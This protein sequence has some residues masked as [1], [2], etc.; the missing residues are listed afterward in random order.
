MGRW[1]RV[2][3]KAVVILLG[4]GIVALGSLWWISKPTL[5][6]AF[7][8]PTEALPPNPGALIRVEPF[9]RMVPSN[10]QAWRILYTTTRYDGTIAPA[11]AII[12]AS[13]KKTDSPSDV[14]AWTH[15]T[16]GFASACAPSVMEKPF[17][18][19][20][21]LAE[22]IDNG[23]VVVATDYIGL[24]T[25]GPH[26]YLIGEGEARSALDS[27]RAA[28]QM[29]EI[30][31]SDRTIVWGHS[32]GG[33]A[34]MWTGILASSYAPEINL[35]GIAAA[36]PASDLPGLVK[37]AEKTPVGKI[38]SAYIISAYSQT[39]ADVSFDDNV[40]LLARPIVRDMATRCMEGTK[41][42]FLVGQA[43]IAG[44]TIFSADPTTGPLGSR[45]REN[46]PSGK[47]DAPLMI[48][49]GSTDELVLPALQDSFVR[50]RCDAGQAI[51]YRVYYNE[52]HLSIVADDSPL[53][54]ELITWTRER[55]EGK[56][57]SVQCT[58]TSR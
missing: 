54:L 52:D 48:A 13:T 10:A 34:A 57:V 18:N 23:W 14:V 19:V 49:Q 27:I 42:L 55:F 38:L 20:P 6:D 9:T 41:A 32:Q 30:S 28:R 26:P 46:I 37:A 45:L 25:A 8:T 22:A 1:L 3:L 16:T 39:Y 24:G 53:K 12:L 29:K 2:L 35:N 4:L 21:A 56:P 7:Y 58:S 40:R 11:S 36:A 47:I 44:S 43:V 33:N 31:V 5:P 51:D 17:A 50:A 15:G